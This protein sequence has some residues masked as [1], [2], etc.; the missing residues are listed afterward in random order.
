LLYIFHGFFPFLLLEAF[1]CINVSTAERK[2]KSGDD[3]VCVTDTG[4]MVDALAM[5]DWTGLS[6]SP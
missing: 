3:W 2:V 4:A 5:G 1:S 6:S